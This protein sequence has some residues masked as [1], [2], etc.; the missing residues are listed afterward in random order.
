MN[1]IA[2]LGN[3]TEYLVYSYLAA[4]TNLKGAASDEAA[5]IDGKD[6]RIEEMLVVSVEWTVDE[7]AEVVVQRRWLGH[8]RLFFR[9]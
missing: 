5:V 4:V 9:K 6:Q 1:P 8:F 7:D 3:Y 2:T